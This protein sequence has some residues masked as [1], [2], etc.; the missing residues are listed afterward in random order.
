MLILAINAKEIIIL[1]SVHI[2]KTR[3][4]LIPLQLKIYQTIQATFSCKPQQQLFQILIPQEIN[5]NIQV[6]FDS[7]SQRS[8]INDEL[9][10]SLKLPKIRS[11]NIVVNI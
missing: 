11:E 9:R 1:Q 4:V 8:Y 6:I 7:V 2:L 10:K 5:I 3:T